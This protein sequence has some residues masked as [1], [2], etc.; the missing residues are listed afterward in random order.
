VAEDELQEGNGLV[1]VELVLEDD[2]DDN[3]NEED[4]ETTSG[5]VQIK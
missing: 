5:Q 4:F 2:D 1:K 3:N